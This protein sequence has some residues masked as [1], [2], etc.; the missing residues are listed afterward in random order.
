MSGAKY[1]EAVKLAQ[2]ET[3]KAG[4]A[5]HPS[6]TTTFRPRLDCF[7]LCYVQREVLNEIQ[8]Q[9]LWSWPQVSIPEGYFSRVHCKKPWKR[10]GVRT[11]TYCTTTQSFEN[12]PG[13]MKEAKT[14]QLWSRI[15]KMYFKFPFKLDERIIQ[16]STKQHCYTHFMPFYQLKFQHWAGGQK[17]NRSSNWHNLLWIFFPR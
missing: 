3:K 17:I 10:S 7:S 2:T 8:L 6:A 13:N 11:L 14:I 16:T 5:L 12:L 4:H 1:Q 9:S 15:L